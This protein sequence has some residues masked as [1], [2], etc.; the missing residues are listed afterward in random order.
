MRFN[1]LL[2]LIAFPWKAHGRPPASGFVIAAKMPD[3]RALSNLQTNFSPYIPLSAGGGVVTI[4]R[5]WDP[6]VSVT[7]IPGWSYNER[8]AL[9]APMNW[10]HPAGCC[11]LVQFKILHMKEVML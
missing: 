11:A 5:P 7:Q 10:P 1:D 6:V 2:D 4:E 3:S 9:A 8:Q